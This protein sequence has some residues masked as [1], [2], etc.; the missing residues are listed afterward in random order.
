MVMGLFLF[1]G[2]LSLSEFQILLLGYSLS[3]TPVIL[4]VI[5]RYLCKKRDKDSER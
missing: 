2:G 4:V 3:I 5:Y 1:I